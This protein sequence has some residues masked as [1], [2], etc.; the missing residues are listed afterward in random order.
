MIK[1]QRG[2]PSGEGEEAE[3]SHLAAQGEESRCGI[4]GL[5]RFW[6]FSGLLVLAYGWI[7]F[8]LVVYSA[9]T[10]IHSHILLIP[11]V[12]AYL[13]RL[14]RNALPG[15]S[16]CSPGW[17]AVLAVTG[18]ALLALVF[19]AGTGQGGLSWNDF[20]SLTVGSFLCFLSAGGFLFLGKRWMGIVSFPAAFLVFMVPLPDAAV[21]AIE[22]TLMA[23]TS[24]VVDGLFLIAGVPCL[25]DGHV[26]QIP[27]ITL[28]VAQECSGI[29]SS[30]VLFITS[31]LASYLF[32]RSPWRRALLMAVVIPLGIL[33]NGF[34]IL[35]LAELCIH[36][37]PQMIDSALHHRGGPIFFVLSLIPLFLL[38][39]WLR[40]GES[41][42]EAAGKALS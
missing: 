9:G 40:R 27:G 34:R 6:W 16:D 25:R 12:S 14:N 28:R 2:A 36:Y 7:L 23:A 38:L 35:V 4:P 15:G 19:E 26:F 10:E 18:L 32:L 33:R 3:P 20:L 8:S 5:R 11:F 17:A 13:I 42:G 21:V 24:E 29:R 22:H 30:W 31:L 39:W 37:G 1:D 41:R